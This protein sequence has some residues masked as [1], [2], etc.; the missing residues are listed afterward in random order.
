M[1]LLTFLLAIG[2]TALLTGCT[3]PETYPL[4]GAQCSPTDPVTQLDPLT[5]LPV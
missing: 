3:E 1:K 2:A 4:S 5:C